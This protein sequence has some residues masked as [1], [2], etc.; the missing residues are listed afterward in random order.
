MACGVGNLELVQLLLSHG[1]DPFLSTQINDALCYSAAAQYGCYSAVAVCCA[2]GRRACLRAA[3]RG[4]ARA[5]GGAVLSL[6]EVLAEGAPPA[7]GRPPPFT[8]QQQRALQDA[9][10]YAAETDHLDITLELR[11][12]GVPWSLHAWTLSLAAAAEASLDHVIDQLLQDFLQVCPSDDSHYSKQF[13]YECLPLLFNILRYSKKEGTVLLLADI[14]CAVYGWEPVPPVREPP[15]AAPARV[16][17]S[18]VNNPSL[19]DV[20]FRV[21]GRLFYGHKIVLVSESPRLR[22]M[23]A[24]DAPQASAPLVQINDIRYHIFEQV[25]KYLYSGGCSGLDVAECDVLEVLAA[26]SFFQLMPLQRHCE[27]RAAKS[28][29]LHNLVSVYIHAKVYGATQLLEYCQGFLLQNMVAL[30]T[31]DDSVKRLLF[32]KRLPGHNV[33]GALLTTLQK[34]IESRKNQSKSR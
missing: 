3:V 8:K 32:G 34:R 27:A 15:P 29:D 17:P 18:Y 2:H 33:L 21:E 13:I 23:L 4:G 5:G 28:V 11:A 20:T 14:L 30:L 16:D 25:M 22:A 6:E 9:M 24:G 7:A 31:Y 12:L 19:A 26:A 1:A 10:Y